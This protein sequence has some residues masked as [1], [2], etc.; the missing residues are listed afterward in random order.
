MSELGQEILDGLHETLNFV[1][2][3]PTK[4]R[5]SLMAGGQEIDIRDIREQLG[6]TRDE[7]AR[8]FHFKKKTVQNWEQGIRQPTEHTLAYLRLIAADPKGVY[9]RLHPQE[10]RGR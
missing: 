3:H 4:G 8:A 2:G 6:M 1:K 10:H 5:A 7:F 9:E